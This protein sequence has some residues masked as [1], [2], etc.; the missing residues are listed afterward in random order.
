MGSGF[1]LHSFHGQS[2]VFACSGD[3]GGKREL[4]MRAYFEGEC[5]REVTLSSLLEVQRNTL[6][7]NKY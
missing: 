1:H 7:P 2:T 5:M 6:F 3:M 4:K